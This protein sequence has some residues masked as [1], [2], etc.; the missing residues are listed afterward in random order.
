MEIGFEIVK[1]LL[2]LTIAVELALGKHIEV[3][4]EE[5]EEEEDAHTTRRDVHGTFKHPLG[6]SY[7]KNTKGQ[8]VPI[9]PNSRMI[10]GDDEEDD[11]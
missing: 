9:R 1:I 6:D 4:L 2:L 7:R 5:E 8:Y 10:D 3:Y 11:V